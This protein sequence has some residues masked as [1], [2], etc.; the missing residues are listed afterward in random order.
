[1]GVA[2]ENARRER[3]F[4]DSIR[5][6]T[7]PKAIAYN[8]SKLFCPKLFCQNTL[9]G[10]SMKNNSSILYGL[11][12]VLHVIFLQSYAHA[13]EPTRTWKDAAGKYSI[14]AKLI[15]L[16]TDSVRLQKTNGDTIS[17]PLAKLS[18]EDQAYVK[19]FVDLKTTKATET[20]NP[21]E[22]SDRIKIEA[23]QATFSLQT[24]KPS[25]D[26]QDL[27]DNGNIILLPKSTVC[28]PLTPDPA[29]AI[30]NLKAGLSMLA[31]TDP[32]DDL[33]ELVTL[34]SK[35]ALV[36]IS[37]GRRVSGQPKP[38]SGKL[39]VGQLPKGPFTLVS[40]G[41]E[42][43]RIFDHNESTGQTLLVSNIDESKRGGELVVI[44]G[45][46]TGKPVELYR[47]RLPGI[48]EPGS[49][50]KV[51]QAKL[52]GE[53]LALVVVDSVLYCWNLKSCRLIY[54]TD[55]SLIG[56][57]QVTFSANGKWL[58]VPQQDGFSLLE[59]ATGE[60]VGY[61]DAGTSPR[62]VLAFHPDGRRI[63]YCSGNTWGVWD[64]VEA[65]KIASGVVTEHLGDQLTGWLGSDL[66]LTDLGNL[67]DTKSEMLFW[68]Y[69]VGATDSRKLWNN[70][71]IFTTKNNG[72]KLTILPIPDKKA[73]AAL[74]KLDQQKNAMVT[75][76]G[77]E[78]RIEIESSEP[79]DKD[80]LTEAL[81]TSIERAGW[82][83]KPTSKLAVVAKIGRGKP[84]TLQYSSSPIGGTGKDKQLENVN[85]NPFTA[86][87]EIRSGKNV[88]WSRNT[89]NF[90]PPMIFLRGE[91]TVQEAVKK[92]ERPQPEFFSSL[93]IPPRIP[94]PEIAKGL[95]SS[96]EDKGVWVDFP[97]QPRP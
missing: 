2:K 20:V 67:L 60:D 41:A 85:I 27:P 38:P 58:A 12:W 64:I 25:Q 48:E 26:I 8:E 52:L 71:L 18:S 77:T 11:L 59:A 80:A 4:N 13:Q 39:L 19:S 3:F 1:M 72:L 96:R 6:V 51:E 70:W 29:T 9:I 83:V 97:R 7:Y 95:G 57:S 47:R 76:P 73:L 65:R 89:E 31:A 92:Y 53:D 94:K 50:P 17:V 93:Q 45:L 74:G 49:K 69:Y 21:F 90:T 5:F 23:V 56:L 33:S 63:G 81:T 75:A 88:L 91:E 42:A 54:R 36:A 79:V 16:Q 68:S 14:D 24:I 84:Y 87:L 55:K 66:L 32:Y 61:V 46:A 62:A 37:I 10:E 15:D 30:P 44:D 28:E 43:I 40:D 82:I 22:T 34:N 35:Q 86:V 78:V